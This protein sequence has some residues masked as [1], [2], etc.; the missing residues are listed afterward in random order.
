MATDGAENNYHSAGGATEG[1]TKLTLGDLNNARPAEP[2]VETPAPAA[3]SR[4]D[5]VDDKLRSGIYSQQEVPAEARPN[6][7]E[8]DVAFSQ[9]SA[10]DRFDQTQLAHVMQEFGDLELIYSDSAAPAGA[11]EARIDTV[12][13]QSHEAIHTGDEADD[14]DGSDSYN[15]DRETQEA[16]ARLNTVVSRD[17][18]IPDHLLQTLDRLSRQE[19]KSA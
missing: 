7:S 15:G 14:H 5:T 11:T 8:I 9:P 12:A 10:Y 19:T 1:P 13:A 18:Q 16:F 4:T 17:S 2:K 6:R 3:E